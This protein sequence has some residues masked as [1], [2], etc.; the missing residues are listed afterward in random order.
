MQP[1]AT[2]Q[3]D[4]THT[5]SATIVFNAATG[6]LGWLLLANGRL[7]ATA[8]FLASIAG[9]YLSAMGAVPLKVR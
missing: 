2:A 8:A 6:Y 4:Q 5:L 3:A 9:G 1:P 7:A